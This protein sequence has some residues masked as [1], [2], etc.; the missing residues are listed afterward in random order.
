MFSLFAVLSSD[1]SS[2]ARIVNLYQLEAQDL[3]T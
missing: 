1:N 2:I 3:A